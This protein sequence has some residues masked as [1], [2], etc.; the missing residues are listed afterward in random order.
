M[1]YRIGKSVNFKDLDN[2]SIICAKNNLKPLVWKRCYYTT[3]ANTSALT[4]FI[5]DLDS[6]SIKIYNTPSNVK[7]L[8]ALFKTQLEF[9]KYSELDEGFCSLDSNS[10]EFKEVIDIFLKHLS[11]KD[12]LSLYVIKFNKNHDGYFNRRMKDGFAY[13]SIDNAKKLTWKEAEL[14]KYEFKE[15][16]PTIEPI[17][18]YNQ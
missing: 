14:L 12:T 10:L 8:H 2:I 4:E 13:S 6:N 5:K 18:G 3:N 16:K 7:Y 9:K 17:K 11:K 15:Y 1:S